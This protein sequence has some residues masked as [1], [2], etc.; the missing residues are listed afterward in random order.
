MFVFSHI[1]NDLGAP[2]KNYLLESYRVISVCLSSL[3]CVT[4]Q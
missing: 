3:N 2:A 1:V 4:F